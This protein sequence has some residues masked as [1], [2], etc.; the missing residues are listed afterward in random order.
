MPLLLPPKPFQ[1][2]LWPEMIECLKKVKQ[3]FLSILIL[4]PSEKIFSADYKKTD[5][6]RQNNPDYMAQSFWVSNTF[7]SFIHIFLSPLFFNSIYKKPEMSMTLD[8]TP[9]I[10]FNYNIYA[11]EICMFTPTLSICIKN[12]VHSPM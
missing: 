4:Y 1:R 2:S 7:Q 3:L 10:G 11:V 9:F 8:N 12:L 5:N 6:L